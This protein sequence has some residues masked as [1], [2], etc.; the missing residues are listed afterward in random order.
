MG[1]V[2]SIQLEGYVCWFNTNDHPPPHFHVKK[3]GEWELRVFFLME[4]VQFEE[5]FLL[6]RRVSG[7]FLRELAETVQDNRDELLQEWSEK[8]QHG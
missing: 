6:K 5:V 1:R 7:R 3:E 8:V 2:D 4:P